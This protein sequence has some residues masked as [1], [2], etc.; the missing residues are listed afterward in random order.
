MIGAWT[1]FVLDPAKGCVDEWTCRDQAKVSGDEKALSVA[2][3]RP[4]EIIA[5]NIIGDARPLPGW[6]T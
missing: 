1:K 3:P 2:T 5:D 6:G 4:L